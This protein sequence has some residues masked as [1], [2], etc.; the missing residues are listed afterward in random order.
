METLV[1]VIIPTHNREASLQRAVASVLAQ[2]CQDF[3]IIIVNDASTDN[4]RE[5]LAA[6]VRDDKRI[7]VFTNVQ[8]LGGSRSRNVGIAA[9]KGQ[10]IAFLDDDDTWLPM[11]LS[12][13]LAALAANPKAVACSAS[14]QVNY[15][16]NMK[17]IIHPPLEVGLGKLLKSNCLGGA[18]VCMCSAVALNK[19][20]GFD[21]K[22]RSAQ[23]WD[24]WIKLREEGEII[25][26][27][28]VLVQYYVHFKYRIS[29]D[30]QAK[31]AGA[32][33]FYFKYRFKMNRETRKI[34][35]AFLAFIKSRQ[36][37]RR[38]KSR[39]LYLLIAIEYSHASTGR[40]YFISSMPR[41]LCSLSFPRRRE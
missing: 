32:R 31:Y 11:K 14:Y 3:E 33:R 23:D 35:V 34:N 29:N 8:S 41:I 4:T 6:L 21:D 13:Q 20:G 25:S 39:V 22:L 17:K 18:S 38:L 9:A 36:S 16:L 30:M 28:D 10:W 12:A 7:Q 19:I 37:F 15:P 24:L 40:A 1:S 26:L 5:Y 2:T 27:T